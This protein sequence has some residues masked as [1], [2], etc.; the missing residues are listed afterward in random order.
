MRHRRLDE[1]SEFPF[2]RADDARG[3][4]DIIQPAIDR[5]A[6]G[7]AL[8]GKFKRIASGVKAYRRAREFVRGVPKNASGKDEPSIIRFF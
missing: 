8:S 3:R 4:A 1:V 6:R 2:G 7:K 5:R